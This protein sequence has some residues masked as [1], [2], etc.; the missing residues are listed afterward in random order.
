MTTPT[1]S[2]LT[3]PFRDP[4]GETEFSV[5]ALSPLTLHLQI[6]AAPRAAALAARM[7]PMDITCPAFLYMSACHQREG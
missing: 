4:T 2:P 5:R 1:P 7:H 3:I 6:S